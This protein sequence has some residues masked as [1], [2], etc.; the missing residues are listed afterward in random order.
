MADKKPQIIDGDT[1]Q[2]VGADQ[3]FN[4][5]EA[6]RKF[7]KAVDDAGAQNQALNAIDEV[8]REDRAKSSQEAGQA[9]R[10]FVANL[11]KKK[12]TPPVK[13]KWPWQK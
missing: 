1:G 10:D 2:E 12:E 9:D 6:R 3:S 8:L 11:G 7:I 13:K 4:A 5:Q